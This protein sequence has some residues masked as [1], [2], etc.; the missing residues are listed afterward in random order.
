[1]KKEWLYKKVFGI[2]EWGMADYPV[3]ISGTQVSRVINGDAMG[4]S[5]CFPHGYETGNS[6][7]ANRQRNWKKFRKPQW[8][9]K[10]KV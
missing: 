7:I 2:N 3:K 4:C 6:T 10:K 5:W 8:K 1:M 9:V